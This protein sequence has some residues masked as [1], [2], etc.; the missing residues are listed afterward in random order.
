MSKKKKKEFVMVCEAMAYKKKAVVT[1]LTFVE[2]LVVIMI[3]SQSIPGS[4]AWWAYL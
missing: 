2:I 1:V 4:Q 3:M